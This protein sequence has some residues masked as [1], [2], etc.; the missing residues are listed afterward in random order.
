VGVATGSD[1][2]GGAGDEKLLINPD[3]DPVI[4]LV[5]PWAFTF[6]SSHHPPPL[7]FLKLLF[8]REYFIYILNIL[9]KIE[10]VFYYKSLYKMC[11]I[12]AVSC[13][14][15]CDCIRCSKL[16]NKITSQCLVCGL[17][18]STCTADCDAQYHFRDKRFCQLCAEPKYT[19]TFDNYMP[20]MHCAE[21]KVIHSLLMK[22]VT[23]LGCLENQP[24][25][26]AHMD[27]GGCME[28]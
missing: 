5:A 14:S 13:V 28:M 18:G 15:K 12:C 26:M 20:N 27:Y 22:G 7:F 6:K 25:Q 8:L 11:S 23:C 9:I 19:I 24:N 10:Y 3:V 1:G 16:D 2:A 17:E 21:H 4:P